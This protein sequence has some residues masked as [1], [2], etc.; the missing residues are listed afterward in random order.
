MSNARLKRLEQTFSGTHKGPVSWKEYHSAN[1]RQIRLHLKS[2]AA[3][4]GYCSPPEID[5]EQQEKDRAI[6]Q[7][8]RK[9]N[10]IEYP[11][12]FHER[13]EKLFGKYEGLLNE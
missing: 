6:I 12:G 4:D 13:W 10:P 1:C 11:P 7:T 5:P 2:M 9:H 3:K 8:Y